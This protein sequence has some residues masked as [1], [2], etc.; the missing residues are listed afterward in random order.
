VQYKVHD[1]YLYFFGEDSD[2]LEYVKI[3][4]TTT[5]A[6]SE[7]TLN[8]T[9]QSIS[10]NQFLAWEIPTND[11]GT[12]NYWKFENGVW[13]FHSSQVLD[14]NVDSDTVDVDATVTTTVQ[15][16]DSLADQYATIVGEIEAA[17]NQ[18]DP[19]VFSGIGSLSDYQTLIDEA[20]NVSQ[21]LSELNEQTNA[22]GDLAEIGGVIG[23]IS[24]QLSTLTVTLSESVTLDAS[25]ALN[26]IQTFLSHYDEMRQE[27]EKFRIQITLTRTIIIPQ[28]LLT[29][30]NL[31]TSA[32]TN[33][34][35]VSV[36]FAHFA[37]V[38][39]FTEDSELSSLGYDPTTF[40]LSGE[41]KEEL[42]NAVLALKQLDAMSDKIVEDVHKEYLDEMK[43]QT[44]AIKLTTDR[45][46][47]ISLAIKEKID[48]WNTTAS[49]TQTAIDNNTAEIGDSNT[50][51]QQ[52]VTVNDP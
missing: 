34:E 16:P 28:S 24:Q 18:L 2:S 10:S 5:D 39:G 29:A 26:S 31:L 3:A 25:S 17:V 47:I 30:I 27:L 4:Q 37:G 19:S 15:D 12:S 48:A 41:R 33:M 13:T 8:Y 50:T 1:G 42:D 14:V 7:T 11:D 21:T 40:E 22:I 51:H 52:D 38:S 9:Q 35:E 46:R 43:V 32:T 36:R 20:N 6:A 23:Q 49:N 44:D 45:W